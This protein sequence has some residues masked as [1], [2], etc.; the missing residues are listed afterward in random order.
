MDRLALWGSLK[1]VF[2]GPMQSL[3]VFEVTLHSMDLQWENRTK[4]MASA[5]SDSAE[6]ITSSVD[7]RESRF[8]KH[9]HISLDCISAVQN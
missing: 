6:S 8:I 5:E 1:Q 7:P 3:I 4:R 9:T 2:L